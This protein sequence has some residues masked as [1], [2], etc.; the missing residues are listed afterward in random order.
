MVRRRPVYSQKGGMMRTTLLALLLGTALLG[1]GLACSDSEPEDTLTLEE[2]ILEVSCLTEEAA[3]AASDALDELNARTGEGETPE[4]TAA[5]AVRDVNLAFWDEFATLQPPGMIED[6]HEQLVEI[7]REDARMM[8]TERPSDIG[9]LEARFEEARIHINE[10]AEQV[11]IR[12]GVLSGD[13]CQASRTP[14][15]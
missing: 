10:A 14:T 5:Q 8:L 4:P 13:A 1:V 7:G 12:F 2:Y 9:E 6:A 11:G 15:P 3:F